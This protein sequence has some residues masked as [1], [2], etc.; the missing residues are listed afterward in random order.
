[1][2]IKDLS[3]KGQYRYLVTMSR[4][5]GAD[6][7]YGRDNALDGQILYQESASNNG[8]PDFLEAY[9]INE[10]GTKF[11]TLDNY[12]INSSS[13]IL[14]VP[15]VQGLPTPAHWTHY[16]IY[17]TQ[18]IQGENVD[19]ATVKETYLWCEDVPIVRSF[20]LLAIQNGKLTITRGTDDSSK[21]FLQSD[22]GARIY[23]RGTHS[24]LYD[25]TSVASDGSYAN[26]KEN[27]AHGIPPDRVFND[28]VGAIG[29][30]KPTVYHRVSIGDCVE[31]SINSAYRDDVKAGQQ[32][33]THTGQTLIIKYVRDGVGDVSIGVIEKDGVVD[34]DGILTIGIVDRVYTDTINDAI[35]EGRKE[36]GE[37]LY[38]LQTRFFKPLPNGKLSGLTGGAYFTAEMKSS[39][40]YYSQVA[41]LYRTGYY[42]PAFQYNDKPIGSITRLK[43]YPNSLVIFTKN[44]TYYLD[45]SV[46]TNAGDVRL[47][48]YI[49]TF[50]DPRLLTDKIGVLSEGNCAKV[51]NGGEII[52]TGEPAVRFFD[53]YKY[54]DNL[55]DG[56]VQNTKIQKFY[57]SV[58]SVWDKRTGLKL[59]GV[60]KNDS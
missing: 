24:A 34:T 2:V 45:P 35:L 43:E 50:P 40:F 48:E 41:N 51:G 13:L 59:W 26:I 25:I 7:C 42:H 56:L 5:T 54:G 22:K 1:M 32:L 31:I 23:V 17:R 4:L 16:S 10:V 11:K 8:K 6:N 57:H 15:K 38:F 44:S 49:P 46:I 39:E 3:L 52:F 53:G 36:S 18:N 60:T 30:D 58:N 12:I 37:P 14:K 29:S 20:K 55:A 27:N 28:E 47:G 21:M 19:L 9:T 33:I